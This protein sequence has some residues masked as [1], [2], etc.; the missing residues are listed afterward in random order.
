VYD[1]LL[2]QY[3]IPLIPRAPPA[4]YSVASLFLHLDDF[5]FLAMRYKA[6]GF[7]KGKAL[8]LIAR[9]EKSSRCKKRK[10]IEAPIQYFPKD[11][12]WKQHPILSK[13]GGFS[14]L[15]KASPHFQ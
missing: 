9:K 10:V 11:G 4:S 1:P 15:H 7:P 12:S 14:F 2:L 5:S 6:Q 8:Y 3:L 13:G